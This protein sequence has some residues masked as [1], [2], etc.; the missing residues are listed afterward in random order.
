MRWS[1]ADG[2]RATAAFGPGHELGDVA[3]VGASRVCGL[4][5]ASEAA[6]VVAP[7]GAVHLRRWPFR[8][9]P[10]ALSVRRP[11][12][13][14]LPPTCSDGTHRSVAVRAPLGCARWADGWYDELDGLG[15]AAAIRGGDVSATEVVDVA[16]GRIEAAGPGG[17]R[18]RGHP[19]RR[20]AG[21]GRR[22][23]I[24]GPFA[25]VPYLVKSL[26]GEVAG[27]PTS[28]GSRLFADDV[29][30]ADSLAVARA[31][32]A[33]VIV[34]GMTNTPE[35]GKNGSTEPVFHGP[36]R[37]PHDLSR[38]PGGSS[39]GSAAAVAS[40]MVPIAHGNDGGGS[41][42]IPASACGLFGLKPSRGRVPQHARR[43]TRSRTRSGARTR[44]RGPCATA[45]RCSTRSPGPAPG[46]AVPS[47]PGAGRSSPRSAPTRDGCGSGSPRPPARGDESPTTTASTRSPGSRPC[48]RRWATRSSEATFAYDVEAANAAL[49]AV[50]SVNVAD[51]V[52]N[53]LAALGRA[54]RTTTSSRS[55]RM[56]YERGRAMTGRE[57]IG[58]LQQLERAGREVAPFFGEH[59]LLLTPTLPIRVPGA[60]VGRHD[61]ARRRWCGPRRSARSPASST[62]P[63]TR[64]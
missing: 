45:R 9:A 26:G 20:G 3:L 12:A 13:R 43:S 19:V 46:D 44:S 27:L 25:G 16:I 64:R 42:R 17:G 38:S 24:D 61:V 31:R 30:T 5:P 53:R 62:R 33:G 22:L 47:H 39:G 57:V 15:L 49:A 51:A 23:A 48:A 35:L 52:G 63:A 7:P 50:M 6:N 59:D 14:T 40:G 2:R 1:S 4:R 56:L 10:I 55:P 58:A 18:G 41:I 11:P 54:L 28:R 36:T 37:N 34:L 32:A 60:R 29:A 8:H 21:R